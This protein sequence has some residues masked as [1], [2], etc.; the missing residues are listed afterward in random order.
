MF[1]CAPL[2]VFTDV[3]CRFTAKPQV[4]SPLWGLFGSSPVIPRCSRPEPDPIVFALV[5]EPHVRRIEADTNNSGQSRR[6]VDGHQRTRNR[7]PPRRSVFQAL[8]DAPTD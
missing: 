8:A 7:S 2:A 1:S 5:Y 6:S 4:H 3:Y